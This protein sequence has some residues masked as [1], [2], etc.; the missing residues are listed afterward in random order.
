MRERARS[1]SLI[2]CLLVML[3][4]LPAIAHVERIKDVVN[5]NPVNLLVRV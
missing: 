1:S 4:K 3:D 2:V 5:V